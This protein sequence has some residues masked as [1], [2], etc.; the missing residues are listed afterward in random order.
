MSTV[1]GVL[2]DLI[3]IEHSELTNQ[4]QLRAMQAVFTA[5][6]ACKEVVH[7]TDTQHRIQVSNNSDKMKDGHLDNDK[8]KNGFE[9]FP[10]DVSRLMIFGK[11]Q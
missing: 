4:S 7:I 1:G 8:I 3:Q 10:Y 9:N 11:V 6:D 5:L 2:N